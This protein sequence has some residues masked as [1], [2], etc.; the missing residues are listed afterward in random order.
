MLETNKIYQGDCLEVMKDIPDK[1][2][3]MVL[4]SPPYDN[5]RDYKGYTFNFEGIAKE[6]YR[7]L[8][9]GGV[10]V[11]VV[12]DETRKF[13]ESLSSFKQAIYFNKI[14]FNL[15]DTMIYYKQNYAPAYP[16][17]RRYANQFEY[18]FIF[19]KGK[20]KTF[21]PIQ[22]EKVRMASGMSSFSKKD[23]SKIVK[24]V[25]RNTRL[26]KD[27]SN[28]WEYPSSSKNQNHPAVFPDK[29]AEDHI[30]S[31]SNE[32]DTILDPM[33]GSGTTLKMAK[34]NNRNYIGIEISHE[35]IPIIKARL[36]SVRQQT[37]L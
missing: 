32:G 3:D 14:G 29:L 7:V 2:V 12:G 24:Y 9:D 11:W 35:Y 23:G 33:A 15:L 21:N 16:T 26:T 36:S 20:P 4:T 31:W 37:L 19:S 10:V 5:L 25:D 17:L 27:A 1:S 28:V 30:L 18:M 8:K 6:I 34:K 22:K 13:C